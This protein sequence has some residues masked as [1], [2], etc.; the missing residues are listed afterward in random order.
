MYK[1][2]KKYMPL[3]LIN[4][5]QG[6]CG[7]RTYYN[8]II[9]ALNMNNYLYYTKE[10]KKIE[11][12]LRKKLIG[13]VMS[14]AFQSYFTGFDKPLH[15]SDPQI[16]IKNSE[17]LSVHDLLPL[18]TWDSITRKMFIKSIKSSKNI[19]VLSNTIKNTLIDEMNIEESKI[20]LIPPAIDSKNFYPDYSFN[21]YP[22]D[23]K[24]HLITVGDFNPRKRFD[25]LYQLVSNFNNIELYHYGRFNNWTYRGKKL[26]KQYPKIHFI[27]NAP[28]PIL[29]NAYSFADAFIYI[30]DFEGFGLTTLE[31]MSTGTEVIINDIPIFK[32]TMNGYA[33]YLTDN[34]NEDIELIQKVLNKK[35]SKYA[36]IQYTEKY[37]LK[38]FGKNLIKWYENET[39]H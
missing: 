12:H 9:D 3:T 24:F 32:E 7:V 31:A 21:P 37:S 16:P 23:N 5:K 34:T 20:T 38:N 19:A 14:I 35:Q 6:F 18:K 29:R 33:N 17:F 1:K 36:L 11:Y 15:V 10:I 30:S 8:S 13:G 28:I 22:K 27:E 4:V 2:I 25:K 26:L 39:I